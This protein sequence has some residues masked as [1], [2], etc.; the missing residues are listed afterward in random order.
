MMPLSRICGGGVG[1]GLK[2]AS[3]FP[4]GLK[5]AS[6]SPWQPY[7]LSEAESPSRHG[8]RSS[9]RVRGS[10]IMSLILERVCA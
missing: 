4:T 6:P 2:V 8:V 3:P 10:L 5:V 1:G 7:S 9:S